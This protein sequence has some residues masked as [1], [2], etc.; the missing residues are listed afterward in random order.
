M[1][2]VAQGAANIASSMLGGIPATGAIARTATNVKNG[3]RTPVSGMVHAITLLA[4]MLVA[5]PLAK[6]IPLACLAGIL[7]V[8]SYNMGEWHA[9]A[10]VY[11]G[12]L[13]DRAVLITVFL[14]TLIFDL[15]IAIE[16]GMVLSAFLFIKRMSDITQVS[17][18][19][20][21]KTSDK[22]FEKEFEEL[23]P[24]VMLFEI[25]GPLFFGASQKFQ[26]T[27]K[28][29]HQKPEVI[30]LNLRNSSIIDATG[31]YRLMEVI[32]KF[33]TQGT[34]V[35]IT[36]YNSAVEKEMRKGELEKVAIL[37]QDVHACI[38]QVKGR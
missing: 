28:K 19:T 36:G 7:V 27:L 12:N 33:K 25:S 31:I 21:E 5:A 10:S 29:I 24:G 18:L 3:G 6:L 32:R 30:I 38:A 34:E 1:E 16:I 17:V 11:K 22:I 23:P 9:F 8:V 4:I 15:V 26:E 35:Y 14:L 37:Q 20:R 13:Y 2:L